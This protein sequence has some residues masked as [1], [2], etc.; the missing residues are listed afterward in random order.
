VPLGE[1][2]RLLVGKIGE[3]DVERWHL[4][5][6]RP[7]LCRLRTDGLTPTSKY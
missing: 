7:R 3:C 1:K 4:Q 2:W 5:G 6:C